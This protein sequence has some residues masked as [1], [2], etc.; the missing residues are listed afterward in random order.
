MLALLHGSLILFLVRTGRPRQV[1][2]MVTCTRFLEPEALVYHHFCLILCLKLVICLVQYE[3]KST[4]ELW[5]Q[6]RID[7]NTIYQNDKHV[8]KQNN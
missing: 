3:H 1:L 8:W 6:G 4:T 5:G 7:I 2:L